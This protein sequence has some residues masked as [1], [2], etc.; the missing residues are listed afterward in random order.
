MNKFTKIGIACLVVAG[1]LFLAIPVVLA[2]A[3]GLVGSTGTG[4]ANVEQATLQIGKLKLITNVILLMI[5]L[6]TVI[7]IVF[8]AKG[9]S[10]KT[11]VSRK[12]S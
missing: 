1:L 11:K 10:K 7:G 9:S 8:L 3:Y 5:P 4:V 2:S 6:S 12:K